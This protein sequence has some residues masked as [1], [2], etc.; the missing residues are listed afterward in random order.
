MSY[1]TQKQYCPKFC[2]THEE[3]CALAVP[4]SEWQEI[5]NDPTKAYYH[6]NL[7]GIEVWGEVPKCLEE[8]SYRDQRTLISALQLELKNSHEDRIAIDKQNKELIGTSI[9]AL[10]EV[11]DIKARAKAKITQMKAE[12]RQEIKAVEQILR[13]IQEG[14]SSHWQKKENIRLTLEILATIPTFDRHDFF[15]Y[16]DDF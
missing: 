9:R 16:E 4:Q 15:T 13:A 11:D 5:S 8:L 10:E 7:L 6:C 12:V 1:P 14:Q 2:C 3:I